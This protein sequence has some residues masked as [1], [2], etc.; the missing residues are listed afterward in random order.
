MAIKSNISNTSSVPALKPETKRRLISSHKSPNSPISFIFLKN[1][2]SNSQSKTITKA[3]LEKNPSKK[4]IIKAQKLEII[5]PQIM[6]SKKEFKTAVARNKARRRI[7]EAYTAVMSE[8]ISLN[9]NLLA[10]M[11]ENNKPLFKIHAKIGVLDSDFE[12][13]K[14]V[15]KDQIERI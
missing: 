6:A 13:L 3:Q 2:Q 8:K 10:K 7:L 5:M 11:G 15:I 12:T 14:R 4:R 1:I 9:S